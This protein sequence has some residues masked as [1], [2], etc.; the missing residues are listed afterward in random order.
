MERQIGIKR[1]YSLGDFRNITFDDVISNVPS[2]LLFDAT[3]VGQ[4]KFLQL[5]SI[6]LAFRRYLNMM[7]KFPL[8]T[9]QRSIEAL[10]Q[11]R[12]KTVDSI[13][14]IINGHTEA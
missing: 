12:Q 11:I 1:L 7:E 6:E 14:E 4:I 8:T 2:E 9:E 5:I 10:E 13:Q 3:L